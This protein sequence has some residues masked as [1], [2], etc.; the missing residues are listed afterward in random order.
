MSI[1]TMDNE[2][3]KECEMEHVVVPFWISYVTKRILI[4]VSYEHQCKMKREELTCLKQEALH[5]IVS[6]PNND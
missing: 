3:T 5:F 6:N 4:K 1:Q 2:K